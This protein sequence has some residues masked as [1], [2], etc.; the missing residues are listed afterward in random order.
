M[1][2]NFQYIFA[3]KCRCNSPWESAT[4]FWAKY[5][6]KDTTLTQANALTQDNTYTPIQGYGY[7]YRHLYRA[8]TPNGYGWSPED[9]AYYLSEKSIFCNQLDTPASKGWI[10]KQVWRKQT[11]SRNSLHPH[12]PQT[13]S[14]SRWHK[15]KQRGGEQMW[16]VVQVQSLAGLI[17]GCVYDQSLI[18]GWNF[19]TGLTSLAS[20]GWLNILIHKDSFYSRITS[21]PILS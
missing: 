11:R 7:G 1:P 16:C 9:T 8:P 2:L 15:S 20:V 4:E 5:T 10:L 18:L 12:P 17:L 14:M 21:D 19:E 3:L 13:R 6:A